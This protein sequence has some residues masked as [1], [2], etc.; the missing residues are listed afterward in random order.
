MDL[1]ILFH[2]SYKMEY[3]VVRLVW[4]FYLAAGMFAATTLIIFLRENSVGAM[5]RGP[6]VS[7]ATCSWGGGSILTIC[8]VGIL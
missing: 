4:N 7:L 2:S 5:D 6:M 8:G 1:N 3:L